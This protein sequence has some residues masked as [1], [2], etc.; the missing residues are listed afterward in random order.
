MW[1]LWYNATHGLALWGT[2]T[3]EVVS[4]P[5]GRI[6]PGSANA[7]LLVTVGPAWVVAKLALADRR[8][9]R[10]RP[11]RARAVRCVDVPPDPVARARD[12]AGDLGRHLVRALSLRGSSATRGHVPLSHIECFPLMLMASVHWV[13]APSRRRALLLA[14]ALAFGWLSNPY[15]GLMC[16]VIAAVAIVWAFA[17]VLARRGPAQRRRPRGRG[18]LRARATRRGSAAGPRRLVARRGRR[19]L[20]ARSDRARDL[21]RPPDGLRPPRRQQSVLDRH[22]RGPVPQRRWASAPTIWAR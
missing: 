11:E 19:D 4:A 2:S 3:Q 7:L 8:V 22:P 13:S 14:L 20:Q 9:Q 21:R 1:D 16:T 17:A 10:G 6:L 12:R 5:F 15:Y 18:G